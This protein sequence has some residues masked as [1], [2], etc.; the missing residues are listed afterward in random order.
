M[1]GMLARQ[2]HLL[3]LLLL[4]PRWGATAEGSGEQTPWDASARD[5]RDEEMTNAVPGA[6][7]EG[8]GRELVR[9]GKKP[10]PGE[11]RWEVNL[12][13]NEC[14]CVGDDNGRLIWTGHSF[15]N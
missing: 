11:N 6:R 15:L 8:R 7:G 5:A 9:V 4:T 13:L 12:L 1:K 14:T 3:L 2:T 10:G